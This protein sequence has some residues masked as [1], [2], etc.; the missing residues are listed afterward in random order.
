MA[1][2]SGDSVIINL[3]DPLD[4][5]AAEGIARHV[6]MAYGQLAAFCTFAVTR[7]TIVDKLA[8]GTMTL[9]MG[10]GRAFRE[11]SDIE[12]L[13]QALGDAVGAKELF[14][15]SI[16]EL[17][18]KSEGGFDLGITHLEGTGAYGAKSVNIGFKNENMLL[19][20]EV[21]KVMATVPDLIT[22][23][24]TDTL[25]PLTN[26]DT[27]EGQNVAVF[28]VTAAKNWFKNPRGVSNWKP[29]LARFGYEGGYVPV[30]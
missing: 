25:A 29:I 10:V 17:E 28:G 2:S 30:N 18:L 1:S 3:R 8:P 20:D 15:G 27:Q 7:D 6:C 11:A 16:S 26:A 19:R 22:L 4:H 9:C 14:A 5:S 12:E 21:G 24:D 23:V 13:T